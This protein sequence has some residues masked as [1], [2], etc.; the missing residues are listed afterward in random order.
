ME[1][2]KTDCRQRKS[3]STRQEALFILGAPGM[4]P[5]LTGFPTKHRAQHLSCPSGPSYMDTSSD[6]AS[7]GAGWLQGQDLRPP[8]APSSA[9]DAAENASP[10]HDN[11]ACTHRPH[12]RTLKCNH[13]QAKHPQSALQTP[14]EAWPAQSILY[15][16]ST[17]APT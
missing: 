17:G 13:L 5:T 14:R 2:D 15:H 1:G 6:K 7:S 9:L 3:A 11:A 8:R 16:S 10:S 4:P 12:L